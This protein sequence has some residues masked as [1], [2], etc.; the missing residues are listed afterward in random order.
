MN[1]TLLAQMISQRF[2]GLSGLT[3]NFKQAVGDAFNLETLARLLVEA[4]TQDDS[5]P[6]MME[7]TE[8]AK[9]IPVK[10]GFPA[11]L[12]TSHELKRMYGVGEGEPYSGAGDDIPLA[13]AIYDSVKLPTRS[14]SIGYQYGIMELATASAMGVSLE[15]DKIKAARLAYEKHMSKVAWYGE[16]KTGVKGFLNQD[17]V[18]IVAAP[19]AWETATPDEILEDVNGIISDSI[20]ETEFNPAITPDTIVFATS[21]MRILTSRR[22]TDNTE[23][24][25]Y[26]H[27]VKNNMLAL[28]GKPVTFRA[29]KRLETAGVGG[30]RRTIVYC[31]NPSCIEMRIPQD[32]QF[33][34]GQPKGLEIFF[35]GHYLYQ[36]VWLKR[37]DSMRYL[38]VP[39]NV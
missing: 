14:G 32:V 33:L 37:V 20:D 8:Y 34:A 25:I 3:P 2:A 28:E 12:G 26:Q 16:P 6:Q 36:G 11:V 10:I 30:T 38:D 29:T 23:T 7:A 4:E 22:L 5:S 24:T 15:T 17:G 18:S 39:S 21:L 35:P 13:E 1:K 9:F 19:Q 27:I 31:R